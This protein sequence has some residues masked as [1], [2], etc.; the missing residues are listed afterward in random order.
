MD[1]DVLGPNT[2]KF[3]MDIPKAVLRIATSTLFLARAGNEPCG[4]VKATNAVSV[5]WIEK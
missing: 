2:N 1:C 3:K 4:Y 5:V